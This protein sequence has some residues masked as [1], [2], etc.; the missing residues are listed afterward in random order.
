VGE[1]KEDV[2]INELLNELKAKSLRAFDSL[3]MVRLIFQFPFALAKALRG[4]RILKPTANAKADLMNDE[5]GGDVR[6][7]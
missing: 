3:V 4:P 5:P 2:V 6:K 1:V 7:R